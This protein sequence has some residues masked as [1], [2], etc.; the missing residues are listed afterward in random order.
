M[1]LIIA[2]IIGSIVEN[3]DQLCDVLKRSE[4]RL[5]NMYDTLEL[6]I[7]ERT[8]ELNEAN[9]GLRN[10]VAERKKT[11]E[12]LLG[13]KRMQSYTWTSWATTSAT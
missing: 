12:E 6:R 8:A 10:E 4:D 7:K 5:R 11:E 1:F 13:Q 9:E 2:Y 3:K